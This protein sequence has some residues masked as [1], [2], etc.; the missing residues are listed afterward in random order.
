VALLQGGGAFAWWRNAL[1]QAGRERDARNAEAV[2]AL[3]DQSEQALRP[4]EAAKA[5]LVLVAA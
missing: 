1:A 2:A 5:E 4:G 3:L